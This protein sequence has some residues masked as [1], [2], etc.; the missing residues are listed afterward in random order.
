MTRKTGFSKVP[1]LGVLAGLLGYFF[2]ATALSG[3]SA[4]PLIAFSLLS[5][6]LFALAAAALEKR[7]SCAAL[8]RPMRR[9]FALSLL[10]AVLLGA[11]CVLSFSGG[12]MIAR[13]ICVL[14]LVGALS[15]AVSAVF[16]LRGAAPAAIFHV[17]A[18]LFYVCRLFSDFR[19][20]TVD[21]AILDYCFCLLALICFMLSTYHM[22]AF[23]LDHGARRRL[24]FY[25]LGGVFFGT[26]SIAALPLAQALIYGAGALFSL[27]FAIQAFG[28]GK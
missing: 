19:R 21:P 22:G 28:N 13:L 1:Y 2:H 4:V 14:G 11:G 10:A 5:A 20:W 25:S 17:P 18:T 24:C 8:F 3:G 27:A 6:A 9:D 15:L 12:G 7:A 23:S 26:V 16:R